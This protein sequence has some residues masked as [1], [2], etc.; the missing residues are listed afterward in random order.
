MG[1]N[2]NLSGLDQ[3]KASALLAG[4]TASSGT[5][6]E[7]R[8]ELIDF[9]PVQP[10]RTINESTLGELA[11]S[12]EAQGVLEPVS[13]RSHPERAGRYIVNRGERRVRASR[14]AGK[15]TVPAFLDDRIRSGPAVQEAAA[16]DT[17]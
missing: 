9:D 6:M 2:M 12:I 5:P 13:L 10:R 4:T 11:A 7:V 15:L 1:V 14:L 16:P 8:L 3:F 17:A